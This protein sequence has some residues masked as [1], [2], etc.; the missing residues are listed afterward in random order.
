MGRSDRSAATE[1]SFSTDMRIGP[2]QAHAPL[3]CLCEKGPRR[4]RPVPAFTAKDCT[5]Y[6]RSGGPF[7]GCSERRRVVAL[8]AGMFALVAN[9]ACSPDGNP[10]REDRP[11]PLAGTHI[12][13]CGDGTKVRVDFVG[14]GL[15]IDFASLPDGKTE[16]LTSPAAGVTYFGDTMNLAITSGSIV[17]IRPDTGTQ[18]CRRDSPGQE[19]DGRPPP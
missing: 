13:T 6:P 9:T 16:R 3:A 8:V 10:D 12:F 17:V 14:N 4:E 15:T 5:P 2:P 11:V 18:V 7:S 19:R 1:R